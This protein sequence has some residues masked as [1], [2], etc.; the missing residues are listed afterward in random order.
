VLENNVQRSLGDADNSEEASSGILMGQ[1]AGVL[2]GTRVGIYTILR[3]VNEVKVP[4]PEVG[5]TEHRLKRQSCI[6]SWSV[7][8]LFSRF[9]NNLVR[10]R[11]LHQV[12]NYY[13]NIGRK[14]RVRKGERFGRG[15][16]GSG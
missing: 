6:R 7:L 11:V 10:Q 3:A 14:G 5:P 8:I 13:S 1:E 9:S 2:L 12:I 16:K 4:R 15:K